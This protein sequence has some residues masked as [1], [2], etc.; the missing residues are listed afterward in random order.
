MNSLIIPTPRQTEQ[1]TKILNGKNVEF[2][3]NRQVGK[4]TVL[5]ACIP[6]LNRRGKRTLLI[7]RQKFSYT[8][9]KHLH[10]RGFGSKN[11]M[12]QIRGFDY[13]VILID[14][15]HCIKKNLLKIKK[16]CQVV[17]TMSPNQFLQ[18]YE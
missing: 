13:D 18:N 6:I 12:N 7:S 15:Y 3:W 1:I 11:D 17:K 5:H 4:T 16:H 8:N 9:K 2:I 14:D 10:T